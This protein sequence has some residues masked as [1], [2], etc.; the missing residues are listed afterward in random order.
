MSPKVTGGPAVPA[1][2]DDEFLTPH[3]TTR[4]QDGVTG[5]EMAGIDLRD[6]LP[7]SVE[8][9]RVNRCRAVV[10]YLTRSPQTR[11]RKSLPNRISQVQQSAPD[12]ASPGGRTP[13]PC[14]EAA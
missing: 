12:P 5:I 8:T 10:N 9:R 6:G 3:V 13:Q 11:S 7:R 14:Q 1:R 4:E 2:R